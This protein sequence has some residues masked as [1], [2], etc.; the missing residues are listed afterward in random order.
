MRRRHPMAG[1]ISPISDA[2]VIPPLTTQLSGPPG[3]LLIL[4]H[5][6][7]AGMD[8]PA[9][10]QLT[11]ALNGAGIQVLRFEFPYMRRIRQSGIR[12][13]PDRA[14]VLL[15][16]WEQA[17]ESARQLC[18]KPARLFVGGK[19]MGG[20]MASNLLA[21]SPVAQDLAGGLC[22]GYPFHPPARA[23]RWRTD[24]FPQLQRPLWIAQGERDP[25]GRRQEVQ[26]QA[27]AASQLTLHWVTDADHD[28]IPAKR[29]GLTP[30]AVLAEVATQASL[31]MG[32]QQ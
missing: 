10:T 14:A 19:S 2:A 9:M 31:F 25:F 13:P 32:A 3:P 29:S 26:D 27:L 18:P 15:T 6:A 1:W 11:Q 30:A 23:D 4:A 5:G 16:S 8:S 28:L 24:H 21:Q 17:L 20:R 7:G 12:R 22:F